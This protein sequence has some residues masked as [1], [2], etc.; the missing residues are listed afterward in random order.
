MISSCRCPA[1]KLVA[2]PFDAQATWNRV[3]SSYEVRP[4]ERTTGFF[5]PLVTATPFLIRHPSEWQ[6]CSTLPSGL[7]ERRGVGGRVAAVDNDWESGEE[8]SQAPRPAGRGFLP[9]TL[10][11]CP[12]ENAPKAIAGRACRP[13]RN[14]IH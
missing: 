6:N 12:L 4:A 3:F 9:G 14:S 2:P 5:L 10:R 13:L 1:Y 11:E 8:L 7:T